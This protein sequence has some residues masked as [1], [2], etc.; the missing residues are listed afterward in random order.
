[1]AIGTDSI[2]KVWAM[3]AF[4][5]LIYYEPYRMICDDKSMELAGR[6]SIEITDA[7]RS[8]TLNTRTSNSAAFGTVAQPDTDTVELIANKQYDY[9]EA[10]PWL[11]EMETAPSLAAA[12]EM[13]SQNTVH[14]K[15]S[16]DIRAVVEAATPRETFDIAVK[17]DGLAGD[18]A[19]LRNSKGAE[20]IVENLIRAEE[21]A[22]GSGW[23]KEGR[24]LMT[25]PAIR[26]SLRRWL[27]DHGRDLPPGSIAAS[28]F[29]GQPIETAFG[30]AIMDVLNIAG[31]S[32]TGGGI[33]QFKS[34]YLVRGWTVCFAQQLY[35]NRVIESQL[36]PQNQWQGLI[37]YGAVCPAFQ[38]AAAGGDRYSDISAGTKYAETLMRLQFDIQNT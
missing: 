24:A 28:N 5:R 12:V 17:K 11:D 33:D 25:H 2:V 18:N 6:H 15:V 36:A 34:H 22:N 9:N 3:E 16:D 38:T 31:D 30:W 21:F 13:W 1:M 32:A 27:A 4:R 23:P 7:K 29:M 8:V 14:N 19:K 26:S 20:L 35:R 10:V 37:S